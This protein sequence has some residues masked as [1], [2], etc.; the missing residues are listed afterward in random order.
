MPGGNQAPAQPQYVPY[1]RFREV[2]DQ[3]RQL[4]YELAQ[5][6]QPQPPPQN[7]PA[8]APPPPNYGYP[9]QPPQRDPE[10]DAIARASAEY[11]FQMVAPIQQQVASLS[12]IIEQQAQARQL[13]QGQSMLNQ[14][15]TQFP[16]LAHPEIGEAAMLE[17][18]ARM[19]QEPWRDVRDVAQQVSQRWD[20]AL[21]RIG[22]TFVQTAHGAAPTGQPP[23]AVPQGGGGI[24]PVPVEPRNARDAGRMYRESLASRQPQVAGQSA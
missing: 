4:R 19:R 2:N 5:R 1:E 12:Q 15:R 17:L 16:V 8:Y 13:E 10:V 18:H 22:Q 9:P 24:P 20:G 3:V 23:A 6:S 11:M 7:Q 21:Q 14:I